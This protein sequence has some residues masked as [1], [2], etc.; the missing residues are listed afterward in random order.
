MK[1]LTGLFLILFSTFAFAEIA[2]IVHPSNTA[3][4]D[5]NAIKRI[6][7]GKLKSYSTGRKAIPIA[8]K[9]GTK[10][11][12]AFNQKV[13]GKSASQLKAYWSKLLFT[14]KGTPPKQV[15]SDAEMLQLIS[16]NPDLIG[17]IDSSKVSGDVKVVTTF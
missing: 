5:S 13:I 7:L 9:E 6:Y 15:S 3:T 1:L 14:G 11:S 8:F 2:V 12:E 10:T 16:V 17:F 4:L